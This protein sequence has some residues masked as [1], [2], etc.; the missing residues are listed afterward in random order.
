MLELGVAGCFIY[1]LSKC[2]YQIKYETH[3]YTVWVR[4]SNSPLEV[5]NIL[6]IRNRLMKAEYTLDT[7]IHRATC[8]DETKGRENI[9]MFLLALSKKFSFCFIISSFYF[10]V[11]LFG[12]DSRSRKQK[13]QPGRTGRRLDLHC[14]HSLLSNLW[15]H[16][17]RTI[18][19]PQTYTSDA[20]NVCTTQHVSSFLQ[21]SLKWKRK[22][23]LLIFSVCLHP[24]LSSMH[25]ACV[26]LSS[27]ACP[28]VEYF[29]TLH[30]KRHYFRTNVIENKILIFSTTLCG[31][32]LVV[33]KN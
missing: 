19:C 18:T 1:K 24:Q 28:A 4:Y 22:K 20:D 5:L 31:I 33:K 25:C 13:G 17:R 27:V 11:S 29:S 26:I 2:Y 23:V 14:T 7:K 30:H 12:V 32:C 15:K 10:Y 3:Q 16:S 6:I 9:L 21:P 8:R